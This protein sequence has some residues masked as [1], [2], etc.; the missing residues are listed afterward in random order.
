MV[1]AWGG[2]DIPLPTNIHGGIEPPSSPTNIPPQPVLPGFDQ[3]VITRFSPLSWSIP[4]TPGFKIH[5]PVSRQLVADIAQMQQE[6]LKKTGT[7]YL[8][9]LEQE[10]RAMGAGDGDVAIYVEKLRGNGKGFK[11]FLVNF[12]GRGR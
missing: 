10:L 7:V 6:I 11:D 2:P 12:L 1:S 9:A 8:V 5:D 3:F 4:V